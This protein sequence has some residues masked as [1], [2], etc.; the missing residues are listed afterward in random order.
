MYA[1]IPQ[2]TSSAAPILKRFM[3]ENAAVAPGNISGRRRPQPPR[4]ISY[5]LSIDLTVLLIT[6]AA[7][8]NSNG[9]EGYRVYNGN[10]SKIVTNI[11]DP[12][13]TQATFPVGTFAS[14]AFW[15]SSYNALQ[16]SVQVP[17][18]VGAV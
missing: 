10:Q 8:Q 11:S 15:V 3:Q 16:E 9:I 7:P 18:V 6:W 12:K 4:S 5:K 1:T 2:N 13:T 14:G 17:L